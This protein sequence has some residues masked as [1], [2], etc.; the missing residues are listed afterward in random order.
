MYVCMH[1]RVCVC[2][3]AHAYMGKQCLHVFNYVYCYFLHGNYIFKYMCTY[4]HLCVHICM[5]I[6]T[7][8]SIQILGHS[9]SKAAPEGTGGE[10]SSE[11][12]SR[13]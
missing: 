12:P 9:S 11:I 5:D 4:M 6:F 1:V 8:M 3:H 2:V 7:L 10:E 13:D